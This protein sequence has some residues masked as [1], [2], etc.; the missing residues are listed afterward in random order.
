MRARQVIVSLNRVIVFGVCGRLRRVWGIGGACGTLAGAGCDVCGKKG[1]AMIHFEILGAYIAAAVALIATPGPVFALV[2]KNTLSAQDSKACASKAHKSAR[3]I[4]SAFFTICG[5]NL[6]SLLLIGVSM[7]MI[8][9]VARVSSLALAILSL[10]G[11]CFIFYLGASSLL[12]LRKDFKHAQNK[13]SHA[14]SHIESSTESSKAPLSHS[15]TI[16]NALSA[17]K[18]FTQGLFLALSNPKDI[19]FFIA[20]FPQFM[21]VA[22][23]VLAGIALLAGLW[24]V[25]DFSLLLTLSALAQRIGHPR[26]QKAISIISDVVLMMIGICGLVYGVWNLAGFA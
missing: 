6:G 17:R 26:H 24:I 5:T 22:D 18:C 20:F 8:L 19:L 13:E 10:L 14:E 3:P 7:A 25:L 16:S 15:R 4:Q 21:G 11:S 9:G 12:A 2:V 1:G 23:S